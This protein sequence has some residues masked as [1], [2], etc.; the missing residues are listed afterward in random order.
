LHLAFG[1]GA[2]IAIG[3]LAG[4][5]MYRPTTVEVPAAPLA[6]V[7]EPVPAQPAAPAEP[8]P[9]PVKFANPFDRSEVFEF[10]AGT[11]P[12][13]ARRKVAELLL[14]RAQERRHQPRRLAAA[15]RTHTTHTA[16]R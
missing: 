9:P 6:L 1:V 7:T 13:E 14:A 10:P 11:S 12:A 3:V 4:L 5:L 16:A 8:P 2:V 15:R